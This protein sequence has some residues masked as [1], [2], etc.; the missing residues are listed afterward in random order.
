ML[1]RDQ[2]R[3]SQLADWHDRRAAGRLGARGHGAHRR[4]RLMVRSRRDA[5]KLLVRTIG[6]TAARL[7]IGVAGDRG[8]GPFAIGA[9]RGSVLFAKR[10]AEMGGIIEAPA[11]AD[12]GDQ[13]A[14]VKRIDQFGAAPLEPAPPHVMAE[15][16]ARVLEQLLDVARGNTLLAHDDRAA[17]IMLAE[18]RLDELANA[19]EDVDLGAGCAAQRSRRRFVGKT[20]SEKLGH[21]E[22]DRAKLDS[23][24]LV[25]RVGDR[26][27][28]G[29]ENMPDALA[30]GEMPDTLGKARHQPRIKN[31]ARDLDEERLKIAAERHREWR[32]QRPIGEVAR[33]NVGSALDGLDARLA[34]LMQG[35]PDAVFRFVGT[36]A[37]RLQARGKAYKRDAEGRNGRP[38]AAVKAAVVVDP[39]QTQGQAG[40]HVLPSIRATVS[41]ICLGGKIGAV[42]QHRSLS[43][44]SVLSPSLCQGSSQKLCRG[45]FPG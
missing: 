18:M 10:P 25:D 41:G 13:Q 15:G 39:F 22:F 33:C 7:P 14:R 5:A 44:L 3:K 42:Q 45:R 1:G 38:G 28:H 26:A 24:Q 9:R 17:E 31:G 43:G 4:R 37:K 19:I 8:D 35:E 11:I 12:L 21:R 30:G 34:L 36:A 40:E 20:R 32:T 2:S 16:F 27:E 29:G 6:P 23:R